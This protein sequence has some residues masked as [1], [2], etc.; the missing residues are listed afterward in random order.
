MPKF[1]IGKAFLCGAAVALGVGL[2]DCS[3]TPTPIPTP[4]PALCQTDLTATV[5]FSNG[6]SN[7]TYNLI[8][9]GNTVATLAPAAAIIQTEAANVTHTVD[10]VFANSGGVLACTEAHPIWSPCSSASLSCSQNR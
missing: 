2:A 6:S 4:S 10:F 9:D 5:T 8:V 3:S 1:S 7:A